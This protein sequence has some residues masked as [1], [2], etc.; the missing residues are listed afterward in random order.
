MDWRLTCTEYICFIPSERSHVSTKWRLTSIP[1]E[2]SHISTDWRLTCI[3]YI[4]AKCRH[5][6]IS[7]EGSRV[8]TV[9]RLAC[10]KCIVYDWRW[11]GH[12]SKPRRQTTADKRLTCSKVVFKEWI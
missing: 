3:E 9:W 8:S 6:S 12:I 4:A 5:Y 11:L 1:S 2:W 7:S 10:T